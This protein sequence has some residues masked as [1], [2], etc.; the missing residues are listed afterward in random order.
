MVRTRTW[1][2]SPRGPFLGVTTGLAEWRGLPVDTTR[3]IVFLILVCTGFF[4]GLFIYMLLALVLPEQK[5]RDIESD[6]GDYDRY[7][8]FFSRKANRRREYSQYH[9]HESDED[10]RRK[11]EE[12]KKKVEDLESQVVDREQDWDNRFNS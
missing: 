8:D 3:L 4:P 7:E 5:A 6:D 10:L 11:Y 9:A 12:L 2:R 1:T